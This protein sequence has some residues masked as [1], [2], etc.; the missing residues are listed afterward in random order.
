MIA[1]GTSQTTGTPS[2]TVTPQ[3]KE[4]LSAMATT[5]GEKTEK[6]MS[7]MSITFVE[8]T[9]KM[10]LKNTQVIVK[11]SFLMENERQIVEASDKGT[12]R[13]PVTKVVEGRLKTSYEDLTAYE[14]VN[15]PTIK[16]SDPVL[17]LVTGEKIRVYDGGDSS[18][19]PAMVDGVL[20]KHDTIEVLRRKF[21]KNKEKM[22]TKNIDTKQVTDV[23]SYN[24]DTLDTD[25]D[26]YSWWDDDYYD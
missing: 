13:V 10:K 8:T 1:T 20:R 7:V 15:H 16:E 19:L 22:R 23:S 25:P 2:K 17:T 21:K 6:T 24:L 5:V 9:G 26:I 18:Y 12:F 3:P 11:V 14:L 4:L